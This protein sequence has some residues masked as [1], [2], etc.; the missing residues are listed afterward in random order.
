[1][2]ILIAFALCALM[3][4]TAAA[5]DDVEYNLGVKAYVAEDYAAARVHWTRATEARILPAFNNL[6]YLLFFG[7]GGPEEPERAV[8]LWTIA[9]RHGHRE[10]QW[11]LAAAYEEGKGVV[12]EPVAAYAWYRSTAAAFAAA[13]LAD[14][15]NTE[16]LD[17][18][19]ASIDRLKAELSAA[20]LREAELLAQQY[21][22]AYPYSTAVS[23]TPES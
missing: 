16:I 10:A 6:G 22:A 21:I 11:H 2:K 19:R 15:A 1:M 9:A 17:D 13:P 5:F 12:H 8:A 23:L 7:M 3:S 18:T 20:Q 14:G 4:G